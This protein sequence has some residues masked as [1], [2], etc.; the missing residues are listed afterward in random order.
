MR[1]V[2]NTYSGYKILVSILFGIISLILN[3]YGL[4]FQII[5]YTITLY[6]GLAF[7]VMIAIVWGWRYGLLSVISGG[8]LP[9]FFHWEPEGYGTVFLFTANVCWV[10]WHGIWH[11][12]R[13]QSGE[14]IWNNVI[15]LEIL[16]RAFMVIIY[17]SVYPFVLS[18]N[19]PFWDKSIYLNSLHYVYLINYIVLYSF[20]LLFLIMF[21]KLSLTNKHVQFLFKL[22]P[23]PWQDRVRHLSGILMGIGIVLWLFTGLFRYYLVYFSTVPLIEILFY[24]GF[25]NFF[26]RDIIIISFITLFFN[27][28]EYHIQKE[29]ESKKTFLD[30]KNAEFIELKTNAAILSECSVIIKSLLKPASLEEKILILCRSLLQIPNLKNHWI[31]RFDPRV[32]EPEFLS[33][34]PYEIRQKI[35]AYTNSYEGKNRIKKLLNTDE[36]AVD[37]AVVVNQQDL[38]PDIYHVLISACY[39]F[40]EGFLYVGLVVEENLNRSEIFKNFLYTALCT[41]RSIS[42]QDPVKEDR[43]ISTRK[44]ENFTIFQYF[45]SDIPG[46]WIITTPS[47][48]IKLPSQDFCRFSGYS[49]TEITG[50]D[51]RS[52]LTLVETPESWVDAHKFTEGS[53]IQK[54]GSKVPVQYICS[55][56]TGFDSFPYLFHIA[57]NL[58]GYMKQKALDDREFRYRSYF[59]NMSDA[60][61][62]IDHTTRIIDVNQ[63]ACSLFKYN[64]NEIIGLKIEDIVSKDD[65]PFIEF[66]MQQILQNNIA[67]FESTHLTKY[68]RRILTEVHARRFNEFGHDLIHVVLRNISERKKQERDL[69]RFQETIRLFAQKGHTVFV[70][71]SEQGH[72]RYFNNAALELSGRSE[73]E[74]SNSIFHDVFVAPEHQQKAAKIFEDILTN[75]FD[76]SRHILPA[77]GSE[78]LEYFFLWDFTYIKRDMLYNLFIAAGTDVTVLYKDLERSR[79]EKEQLEYTF[80]RA[81]LPLLI[82]NETGFVQNASTSAETI[83]GYGYHELKLLSLKDLVSHEDYLKILSE[84]EQAPSLAVYNVSV[85]LIDSRDNTIPVTAHITIL[86]DRNI[87]MIF[88]K[89]E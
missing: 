71:F 1:R 41:F 8:Y 50:T 26:I 10:I 58:S 3:L 87:M 66:H 68:G 83:L 55:Q 85:R 64:R 21:F 19:P 31:I 59:N 70:G 23:P 7:P 56:L 40:K 14:N 45:Y 82:F 48:L 54:N 42:N 25:N 77:T 72:I 74:L 33:E 38:F 78:D 34:T 36:P 52:I 27:I 89:T 15:T 73:K 67:R 16:Y 43:N 20:A 24:H 80:N 28:Y 2:T 65:K 4:E 37:P 44:K 18:L 5:N 30:K 9:M 62:V 13:K 63:T 81:P 39:R 35:L 11:E 57:D 17:I 86:E 51:L 6:L 88:Q 76:D 22:S 79:H 75:K 12:I 61:F 53:V 49:T 46:Y 60:S 47:L 69:L 84:T 29:H 32:S